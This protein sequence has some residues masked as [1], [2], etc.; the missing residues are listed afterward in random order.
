MQNETKQTQSAR[1][2][3]MSPIWDEAFNFPIETGNEMIKLVLMSKDEYAD[4]IVF[5]SARLEL[6]GPL[7][8]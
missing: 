1:E 2:D 5:G 6:R 8:D 7:E 3:V 4:P